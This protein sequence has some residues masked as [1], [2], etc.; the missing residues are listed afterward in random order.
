MHDLPAQCVSAVRAVVRRTMLVAAL[1]AAMAA[2]AAGLPTPG[3][4][5]DSIVVRLRTGALTLSPATTSAFL[6]AAQAHAYGVVGIAQFT[7]LLSTA[8]RA[9]LARRG[10]TVVS[11]IGGNTYRVRASRALAA[12][13]LVRRLLRGMALLRPQDRV[14]PKLWSGSAPDGR[15]DTA[16]AGTQGAPL[17]VRV[18]FSTGAIDNAT[19]ER[20]ASVGSAVERVNARQWRAT[21]PR[22]SIAAAAALDGVEWIEPEGQSIRLDNDHTRTE[23]NVE[24]LQNF[25]IADARSLGSGGAGIQVGVFDGGIDESHNDFSLLTAGV[26]TGSRILVSNPAIDM[27]GTMTAGIIAGNGYNSATQGGTQYQWR[28]MAPEAELLEANI[29]AIGYDRPMFA[30]TMR[31]FILESGMDVSNHSYEPESS[32]HYSANAAQRDSMIRGDA[33][34]LDGVLIPARPQVYSAGNDGGSESGTTAPGATSTETY[35]FFSLDLGETKNGI[36]VGSWSSS[37]HR[38]VG[39]SSLGPTWDGR[40]KPDL[41]APGSRVTMPG[42][43]TGTKPPGDLCST[44]PEGLTGSG[45][46]HNIYML[47]CGTSLAAPVVTG[48]IAD[49]LQVYGATYGVDVNVNPPLPSTVRGLLLHTAHDVQPTTS[50]DPAKP[51]LADAATLPWFSNV[52]GP[53]QPY[54]GPDL[55]TG[56]GLIDADGAANAIRNRM[57]IEG[58]IDATCG[59][60][61]YTLR[62]AAIWFP[63]HLPSAVKVTLVWD[64][65]AS[66][67]ITPEEDPHLVNDLDLV[68]IDPLGTKHYPWRVNQTVADA[69]GN[70]LAASAEACGTPVVV[71]PQLTPPGPVSSSDLSAAHS[72]SGTDHLNNVEQVVAIGPAGNWKVVVSGFALAA[73]PQKFSL[74][75][76]SAARIVYHNPR[77][78]CVVKQ[79]CTNIFLS[80]CQ[81]YPDICHG[82]KQVPFGPRGPEMMFRD[83][84]DRVILPMGQVCALLLD[85]RQCTTPGEFEVTLR[86]PIPLAL[87]LYSSAGARVATAARAAT[88][89]VR[90]RAQPDLDYLLVVAPPP[91]VRAGQAYDV[92]LT[93]RRALP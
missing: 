54:A 49:L 76:V 17:R 22:A 10:L 89:R 57:I 82:L 53:V 25:S 13:T 44:P 67:P 6:G 26:M 23:A 92:A 69:G 14:E 27:H 83:A 80:L 90:Y 42:Y 79:V 65:A 60:R 35:G 19:R 5:E 18:T 50:P 33:T 48:V 37:L 63:W 77:Q 62:T 78:I 64:D 73:A 71:K 8:E 20:L 75:G 87:T 58:V 1:T 31:K 55:A 72:Q 88:T 9:A 47:S 12:D 34:T 84:L 68:L 81:K 24:A 43:W 29:D 41:V 56:F 93:L 28:G 70:T 85:A 61:T 16:S 39:S 52:D 40:L 46:W 86:A 11:F 3:R 7:H 30:E 21:V 32:A 74:I 51:W 38:I 59:T 2:P 36:L 4:L 15:R 66:D 91:Q 45:P